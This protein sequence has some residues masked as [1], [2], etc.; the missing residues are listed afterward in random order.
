MAIEGDVATVPLSAGL[1]LVAKPHRGIKGES[2]SL[3]IDSELDR[4]IS[5]AGPN[6]GANHEQNKRA[7]AA[8]FLWQRFR[9]KR[10]SA[11]QLVN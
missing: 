3:N 11:S 5:D 10:H 4:F 7:P 1:R 6:P 9:R 8:I 2:V